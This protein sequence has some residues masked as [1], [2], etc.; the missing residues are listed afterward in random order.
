V[1]ITKFQKKV[2]ELL[3]T[4][5]QDGYVVIPNNLKIARPVENAFLTWCV[6]RRRPAVYLRA[7][8]DGEYDVTLD[9]MPTGYA[10]AFPARAATDA[11]FLQRIT[12]QFAA[13]D[14][15]NR[16][17]GGRAIITTVGPV[18]VLYGVCS[19]RLARRLARELVRIGTG[20]LSAYHHA[21]MTVS[22]P[23]VIPPRQAQPRVIARRGTPVGAVTAPMPSHK[24][25]RKNLASPMRKNFGST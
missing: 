25:A 9:L 4:A 1:N 3:A 17:G 12:Q 6:D 13:V 24:P 19:E 22:R 16:V 23:P 14:A 7:K 10:H 11:I 2:A 18:S 5:Q 21:T 8:A 15:E 20:W